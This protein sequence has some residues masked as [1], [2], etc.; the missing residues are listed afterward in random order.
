[1]MRGGAQRQQPLQAGRPLQ[2][3]QPSQA[4]Q[5]LQIS[6]YLATPPKALQETGSNATSPYPAHALANMEPDSTARGQDQ[7]RWRRFR[8]DNPEV[9]KAYQSLRSQ[10]ATGGARKASLISFKRSFMD[11]P[12]Q[13]VM[14]ER[15]SEQTISNDKGCKVKPKTLEQLVVLYNSEAVA[16][17]VASYLRGHG[18]SDVGPMAGTEVF[19]RPTQR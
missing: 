15:S 1:M 14:K 11:G 16:T 3:Q 10:V 17:N 8:Q 13:Y 9:E 6:C 4:K 19:D 2:M 5:P 12:G 7:Y 18:A